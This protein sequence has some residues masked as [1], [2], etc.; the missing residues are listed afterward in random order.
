MDAIVMGSRKD[1]F[2]KGQKNYPADQ[3]QVEGLAFP[4]RVLL[5]RKRRDLL[6]AYLDNKMTHFQQMLKEIAIDCP[7]LANWIEELGPI[8]P[9][10]AIPLL[11]A[12]A[13]NSSLFGSFQVAQ[14]HEVKNIL[15]EIMAHRTDVRDFSFTEKLYTLQQHVPLIATTLRLNSDSNGLISLGVLRVLASIFQKMEEQISHARQQNKHGNSN[16]YAENE[17]PFY[18]YFPNFPGTFKRANYAMDSQK[19]DPEEECRKESENNQHCKNSP[20]IFTI[21]CRHSVCLGFSLMENV[22]SPKTPFDIL[23]N[24]FTSDLDRLVV[25]YD[26]AC[27]LH[28]YCMNREP[29]LFRKT[30]FHVDRLHFKNHKKCS[31]GYNINT[32]DANLMYK[33][34]NSQANEQMNALLRNYEAIIGGQC[35]ENVL[36][37]LSTYFVYLS[38]KKK[39][40]I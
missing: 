5:Q 40:K 15:N 1:L 19:T 36:L 18:N 35:P 4:K 20:G 2:K 13:T 12:L 32:Y 29:Y 27:N 23:R 3:Y 33:T 10:E 34:L 22:E 30:K 31:L 8:C 7:E 11:T 38:R 17:A 21:F 25:I 26:N 9:K 14:N 16:Y 39:L 37:Y 24:H 6:N 28:E